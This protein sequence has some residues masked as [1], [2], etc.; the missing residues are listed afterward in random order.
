MSEAVLTDDDAGSEVGSPTA[1]AAA[2]G[3]EV[4]ALNGVWRGVLAARESVLQ[5]ALRAAEG[6]RARAERA[7][8]RAEEDRAALL[9]A[10]REQRAAATRWRGAARRA[11]VRCAV[12]DAARATA[13][14]QLAAERAAREAEAAAAREAAEAAEAAQRAAMAEEAERAERRAAADAEDAKATAE[15]AARRLAALLFAD[16]A[17]AHWWRGPQACADGGS[18]EDAG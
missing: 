6:E 11:L 16:A 3:A 8:M 13:E 7:A 12:V 4:R 5:E 2:A 14:A 18:V 1:A 10:A 17:T 15:A 9:A